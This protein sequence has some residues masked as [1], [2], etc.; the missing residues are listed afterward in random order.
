[1]TMGFMLKIK[2][3]LPKNLL[4]TPFENCRFAKGKRL[5]ILEEKDMSKRAKFSRKKAG[6]AIKATKAQRAAKGPKKR[7]KE[8]VEGV[9]EMA[10]GGYGFVRVESAGDAL[11]KRG[12]RDD[13]FIPSG[14]LRGA[15]NN[16]RVKVAVLK[17]SEG[18]RG[19]EGEI[20]EIVSRSTRPYVGILQIT[21]R[22]AWVIVESKS[23]PYDIQVPIDS[24]KPE[25]KGMKVAALVTKFQKGHEA[26][27]GKIV[28][29]LG[30]P[31]ENDTEMHAILTE[32][33]L[34]YKF[35]D[36]VEAEA[37]KIP[38][39]ITAQELEGRRDFRNHILFTI[40][41]ADAKDFDDAVSYKELPSGNIEVGVHIAD[42]SHYV[43]PKSLID[44]EAY[45]RATS[46]YLVDRTIPML[47]EQLCNNLCSLRPNEDKLCFSALFEMEPSGKILKEWFG[48]S[49]IC[50][51]FRFA[52]EEAQQIIDSN[53]D[54]SDYKP[55]M[56]HNLVPTKEIAE[57]VLKLHKIAQQLRE[58]RFKAGSI[59]F[60]RPE[61][62]VRV[63][64]NGKPIDVVQKITK[65]ANWLIEEFMLL[66]N[67]AVA[68][69][70]AKSVA[71]QA[72][73]FVY[74]IHDEPNMEK[75]AELKT[76]VKHFG[77]KMDAIDTPK[78]LAKSLNKLV[79]QLRGKPECDTI[80]LLALRCMARAQYSTDNIGH[81]GLGFRFY[82]HFTSPIRRYPDL[83]VHR[84]LSHYLNK[85]KS[86]DKQMYEDFCFHC[87]AR[88]QLAT[89]AERTSIRY[90][91]AEYMKERIG[92]EFEG[93]ISGVTEWGLYVQA[94]PTKIEGMIPLR[95]L[96]DD[97][98]SFDEKSYSVKG[99]AFGRRYTLGDKVRIKVVSC[100]LEQKTIDYTLVMEDN[101][102]PPVE[103]KP[104]STET[105]TKGRRKQR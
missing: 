91:M 8:I 17:V 61:M 71:K 59:S 54:L 58:K 29:I 96:K 87:S 66:A 57:A 43:H 51:K 41:P 39:K 25:Q 82:T 44:R 102:F 81:Y 24:V 76:F 20:V 104:K 64:E 100:S 14:K 26:P 103:P 12:E 15:L 97:Y 1:M 18:K 95:E 30:A 72:P 6:P 49:I 36:A 75:V 92:Q 55:V 89:D 5:N 65:S 73:T 63:D 9:L 42:V 35:P 7:V 80:E 78:Q 60:E 98:Y 93:T 52:Y 4:V 85:G 56:E 105:K 99:K 86:V 19:K 68:T 32:F 50:S 3:G 31:G 69:F 90:K 67:K 53:G 10:A 101:E 2:K 45:A 37:A 79:E 33:S 83:M 27:E 13:I 84:L 62:K 23:M 34:P 47:P 77:Y 88:E 40:D 38:I 28:D 94:E 16:D 46:V 22:F 48:K 74:R 21:G 11:K 70:V